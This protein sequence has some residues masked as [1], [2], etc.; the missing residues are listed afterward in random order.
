MI[1][2]T[3]EIVIRDV[4]NLE[5]QKKRERKLRPDVNGT[6]ALTRYDWLFGAMNPISFLVTVVGVGRVQESLLGW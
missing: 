1:K 5:N 6:N 4:L 3:E 2:R